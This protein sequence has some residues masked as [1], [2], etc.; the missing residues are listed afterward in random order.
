MEDSKSGNHKVYIDFLKIIAIYMVLFNH[1]GTSGFVFFTVARTSTLY[2]FYLFNAILIKIAVPLFFMASGALLLGKEESYRDL[3]KKRFFKY[4]IVLVVFS[5]IMYLYDC[6]RDYPREMSV[7]FFVTNLYTSE[8]SAA[9]WYLYAYLAYILML[10]ILRK[11]A[12]AMTDKE[13]MWMFLL[14]GLIQSLT[15]L[16]YLIWKGTASHNRHFSFFITTNYVFYPLMGYYID[17]RMKNEQFQWKK[18]LIL[19]ITSVVS[20]IICCFMTQYHCTLIDEW[21][22]SSCQTFFSTLIFLPAITVFYAVK[23][24]FINHS[25]SDRTCSIIK[26]AGGTTFGIYLAEFICRQETKPV[27]IWV[28][29]Y[30]HTFPACW[31]WI[32]VACICG[33]ILTLL[34]KR[35]PGIKKFI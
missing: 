26:A 14:Y 23:M 10:P 18:L 7:E 31:I 11:L 2:P 21:K 8:L 5:I 6:L 20:V 1:T 15:I 3:L 16:E 25:L 35:I 12:R 27:F 32:L 4:A 24:W 19:I 34:L 29:P 9:Y 17:Q 28:E 22:E 33:G 30:L 13:Y